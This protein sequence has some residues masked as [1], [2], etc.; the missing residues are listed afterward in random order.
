MIFYYWDWY[1]FL[2]HEKEQI[3]DENNIN[4]YGGYSQSQ[5]YIK[6]KHDT[7][8]KEIENYSN[9]ISESTEEYD[10]KTLIFEANKYIKSSTAKQI[11]AV[12]P[13]HLY[14]DIKTG[15]PIT[16]QHIMAV[17]LY[18]G[19][20]ALCTAF[21]STF[22]SKTMNESLESIKSRN[23]DFWWMSKLLRE[24]V[25]LFG[26]D[27]YQESGPFYC[28][29]NVIIAIPQ[30]NI[31]LCGPNSTTKQRHIAQ[32]FAGQNGMVMQLNNN[33]D[34]YS[35]KRLR[36]F[37]CSWISCFKEEDERLFFGGDWR[38]RI[39]AVTLKRSV[40]ENE[41]RNKWDATYKWLTF[42]DHFHALYLMD[43]MVNGSNMRGSKVR[44]EK[45]DVSILKKLIQYKLREKQDEKMSF[46]PF[47]HDTFH[48]FCI[49]KKQIIINMNQLDWYFKEYGLSQI[50]VGHIEEDGDAKKKK[51]NIVN[52]NIFEL[53]ENA[54][55][56]IIY[57]T[58]KR[59]MTS[60]SFSLKSFLTLINSSVR[61]KEV[62]IKGIWD[63]DDVHKYKEQRSWIFEIYNNMEDM[64]ST[65]SISKVRTNF[66]IKLSET[67]STDGKKEDC[68]TIK[69][70]TKLSLTEIEINYSFSLMNYMLTGSN[71]DGLKLNITNRNKDIL[72][73]FID[74]QHGKTFS[75]QTETQRKIPKYLYDAFN[76]FCQNMTDITINIA[77]L[78]KYFE[79]IN[80]VIMYAIKK[81]ADIDGK[82]SGTN[83]NALRSELFVLLPNLRKIKIETREKHWDKDLKRYVD[84]ETYSVS[85]IELLSVI[86]L[87][88]N[89]SSLIITLDGKWGRNWIDWL[90]EPPSIMQSLINEEKKKEVSTVK[91]QILSSDEI[92]LK[93][94]R[95][96][97]E[98]MING[99]RN[100][101]IGIRFNETDKLVLSHF[102][103]HAL[104]KSY[105]D[106][107]PIYIH[108]IFN[109]FCKD[110]TEVTINIDHL[111]ENC[112]NICD[113]IMY[114]VKKD[115]DIDEKAEEN[116]NIF[117]AELF[118][119]FPNL[120][121]IKIETYYHSFSLIGL[122]SIIDS[123]SYSNSLIIIGTL[124]GINSK[125]QNDQISRLLNVQSTTIKNED[126]LIVSTK[127]QNLDEMRIKY[128]FCLMV[129][130]ISGDFP[131]A[132]RFDATDKAVLSHLIDR[133]LEKAISDEAETTLK[134]PKYLYD[135]FDVL[136]KD[137]TD[138]TINIGYLDKYFNDTCDLLMYPIKNNDNMDEKDGENINLC[139]QELFDL[140]PNLKK[141]KIET[142]NGK[143]HYESWGSIKNF[144]KDASYSLSLIELLSMIDLYSHLSSFIITVDG[145]GGKNWIDWLYG[146]HNGTLSIVQTP[147]NDENKTDVLT[148][149]RPK[150]SSDEIK[151][152]YA[153]FV[154]ECMINGRGDDFIG[155]RFNKTDKL[156]VSQ[157]MDHALGRSCNDNIP[158]Y[159]HNIF[160]K[161]CKDITEVTLNIRHLDEHCK[162]ICDLIMYPLKK[163]NTPKND[164]NNK[165]DRKNINLFRK[166]LLVLFPNLQIINIH[167][168]SN[169]GRYYSLSLIDLLSIIDAASYSNSIIIS[170]KINYG[171]NCVSTVWNKKSSMIRD[172]FSAKQWTISYRKIED[173]TNDIHRAE[174]NVTKYKHNE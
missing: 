31:R 174:L 39:Q 150:L 92:K 83:I 57:S 35:S 32:R 145:K 127:Q 76:T 170:A 51:Q 9:I 17:S 64:L 122:L 20:S 120:Q 173:W 135:E 44:I 38:I 101:L 52:V 102:I 46:D 45:K 167:T 65:N 99:K 37:D 152:K 69:R 106:K 40:P 104:G 88:S 74:H 63:Q 166:E 110:I 30:F 114:P 41:R 165:K 95:F 6:R 70:T 125:K 36:F 19:Y 62:I 111:Y 133:Q 97:L 24:T 68:L 158:I 28:G 159:I 136:C 85:L 12:C 124:S 77:Y 86:G 137:M 142:W 71:M 43:C 138:I 87:S 144:V 91:R 121:E 22:R 169:Y 94:A 55:K 105:V 89:L 21:S 109:A 112:K 108:N 117:R 154:L 156:I 27:R 1:Q 78:D 100:D 49:K 84:N 147:I 130:M 11:T 132:F 126:C 168:Y 163:L 157:L 162:N 15:D 72:L 47:I 48:L 56:V 93:Y 23:R 141:I 66:E 98:Y 34:L 5:L 33:G 7:F 73:H 164:D 119:L 60:Y 42:S 25:Q 79:N 2:N 75:N 82:D 8:K 151:V 96:V 113:L 172:R 116:V 146:K 139:R 16:E 80:D 107:S 171:D 29:I 149:K 58:D 131:K 13:K 115:D 153:C 50:I 161:F 14:Y 10:V 3:E 134:I 128:S 118:D 67:N 90:Y 54:K 81:D 123:C 129:Y 160:D 18:C 61:W 143:G 103:D 4:D 53:F 59:G 155:I 26:S 148:V 140:F